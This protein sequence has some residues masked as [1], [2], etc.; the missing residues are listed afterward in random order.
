MDTIRIVL[1]ERSEDALSDG[2]RMLTEAICLRR[3][4][5]D[6]GAWVKEG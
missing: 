3:K 4:I 1:P 6:G 2:L 5:T